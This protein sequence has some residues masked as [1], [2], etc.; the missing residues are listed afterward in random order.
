MRHRKSTENLRGEGSGLTRERMELL[1]RI[2]HSST[3]AQEATGINSGS[4]NRAAKRFGLSFRQARYQEV[5][6]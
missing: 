2:Y 5:E 6:P 3:Y 1:T 4:L